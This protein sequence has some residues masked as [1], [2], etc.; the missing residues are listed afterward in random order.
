MAALQREGIPV[1]PGYRQAADMYA[2]SHALSRHGDEQVEAK[3]GQL[4]VDEASIAAIPEALAAPVP[5]LLVPKHYE[6]RT[7]WAA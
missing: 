6:G 1:T 2:A 3:Q 7:S 4:P 5:G